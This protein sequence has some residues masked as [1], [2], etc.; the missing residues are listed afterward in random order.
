MF[1]KEMV[2]WLMQ[3]S[4]WSLYAFLNIFTLTLANRLKPAHIIGYSLLVIFFIGSTHLYRIIIKKN[5]W[6]K[7][8]I[9]NL[10]LRIVGAVVIL[11]VL[12]YIFQAFLDLVVL[13]IGLA[14]SRQP[15]F[16]LSLLNI[17]STAILYIV[18][19]LIYFFYQYEAKYYRTLRYEA[20]I[21]EFE[22][23]KLKSQLNPHFIFNALNSIR[24]LVD[25]NPVK[26]KKAITQ[27]SHLLRN[28]LVMD[29]MRLTTFEDE[30]KTVKDYLDLEQIRY[31][32]RLKTEFKLDPGSGSFQIPPLMVQTLVENGIK[33]G[34]A[35]EVNGGV[36]RINSFVENDKLLVQIRNTGQ[37]V[38]GKTA[39]G[40]GFGLTNSRQRLQLLYGNRAD[41]TIENEDH[42]TVITQIIIPKIK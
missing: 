10:I 16:F 32:E 26:A 1:N 24:A 29:K 27:L 37:Y 34:I 19:S 9:Y 40:E 42:N 36:I 12:N 4:G 33:H 14:N 30:I 17:I 13:R 25:E 5:N 41:L 20:S 22:L 11:S 18:W 21:H 6:I 31:E 28:S 2:Y 15:Y 38:N 8:P 35:G 7:L 3:L 23:N 39:S